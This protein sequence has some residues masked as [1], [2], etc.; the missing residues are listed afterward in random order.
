MY[1]YPEKVKF[2]VFNLKEDVVK[3]FFLSQF[4]SGCMI[5]FKFT[6][7]VCTNTHAQIYIYIYISSVSFFDY[8]YI[9]YIL[10]L[11]I[12]LTVFRFCLIL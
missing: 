1:I 7:Y 5:H 9:I 10:N 4:P 3:I 12:Y 6:G 2:I 8:L 11:L